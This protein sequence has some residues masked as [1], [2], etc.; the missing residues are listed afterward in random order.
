MKDM[1]NIA[2]INTIDLKVEAGMPLGRGGSSLERVFQWACGI[3]EVESIVFL[4]LP[5]DT[6][7]LP[8]A[9]R[10]RVIRKKQWGE[11]ELIQALRE[12]SR[13]QGLLFYAWGD[14]PLIDPSLTR[15]LIENHRRYYAQYSFADGYPYGLAPE[16]VNGEIL[17]SLEKLVS[18][19]ESLLGRQTLFT[20]LSR[21]INSFDVETELAPRDLRLLRVSLAADGQANFLLLQ[22]LYEKW[23]QPPGVEEIC[24]ILEQEQELLRTLPAYAEIQITNRMAHWVEYLP[25]YPGS[26][27]TSKEALFMEEPAFQ[28]LLDKLQ[29]LSGNEMTL[30]LGFRCEPAHHPRIVELVRAALARPGFKVLLETAGTGWDP[31]VV[32]ALADLEQD[33]IFW[34]VT[35]DAVD[36]EVYRELR[37]G[38]PAGVSEFLDLLIPQFPGRVWVQATRLQGRDEPLENFYRFWK[39]KEVPSIIQK[40]DW[41]CG[42][43]PDRRVTDLSP[44][45]RFACWHLKRDL[46]ILLDGTVLPCREVLT[47]GES[48][49]NLLYDD[50]WAIWRGGEPLYKDHLNNHYPGICEK[51][52]EYYTFNF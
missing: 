29:D 52:D 28:T 32:K 47:H 34:I 30:N 19:D 6:I 36:P 13:D 10:V 14:T 12:V 40:Y 37:G 17:S 46:A 41:Y 48:L 38:D 49:G 45:T 11:R 31:G 3:P 26:V 39:E 23:D 44:L 2:I 20:V 8:K 15:K 35:Q 43:L 5:D 22:R 18:Q 51:C 50:V 33:R 25:D 1:G 42:V 27:L 24:H 4:A 21:D 16:V 9:D 7:E